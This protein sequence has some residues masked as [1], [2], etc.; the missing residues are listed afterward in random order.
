[1]CVTCLF[2]PLILTQIL[3]ILLFP[4]SLIYGS[5]LYLRNKFYDWNIFTSKEFDFPII[6]VGNLTLGGV[7]KTPHVEYLV[8]LLKEN[9]KVAILSRG[10]KRG[11]KGFYL[12]NESSS[13]SEIGDEPLQY[14]LKFTETVIAVDE[15]RVEGIIKIKENHP[16]TNLVLL[17]DAYQHR[18]VK[19]GVNILVT[20]CNNLYINDH[21]VPL[22]RL[23][24]CSSGSTRADIII[25]SKT[26]DVLSDLEKRKL[27][28][29]LKPK[30]HQKIYFS[31]IKYGEIIPFTAAAQNLNSEI[32]NVSNVLLLTGIAK[33]KPLFHKLNNEYTLVEHLKFSDHHNF[34]DSNIIDIK[35]VYGNIYGN[36]KIIITTENDIMRL[37]LP[38]ILNQLK[39]IPIFYIP[40]EICFHGNDKEEFDT[41]IL[42]YVTAN[43]RN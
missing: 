23:R 32:K 31:Y 34:T 8:R 35:K 26:N 4:F 27:K 2:L 36:N 33:A 30:S 3:N 9:F 24:E 7:G 25:V 6:S 1:M 29:R 42:K 22:G 13:V 5:I 12:A 41:Q 15:K 39:E 16:E 43:S 40:I 17:D 28:E 38:T 11:T 10:Y 18:A 37:S 21:V 14:K 19:P 20:D